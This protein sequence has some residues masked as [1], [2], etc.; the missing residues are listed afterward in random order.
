[1]LVATSSR[2]RFPLDGGRC[3]DRWIASGS[4]AV[5][6]VAVLGHP[7]GHSRSP[8]MHNAAFRELGLDWRYEAI[9]VEPERFEAVVREL[10]AQGYAGANVTIPHKLRAL[11]VADTASD[12]R[13]RPWAP[14]TRSSSRT[15]RAR[16]QHRRAGLPHRPARAR[17][18]GAGGMR[19]LVLGAGGAGARRRLRA[20]RGGAARV[21]VWNRHPERAEALVGRPRRVPRP[22]RSLQRPT[23]PSLDRTDLLVNATSVGM[24]SHGSEPACTGGTAPHQG[25]TAIGR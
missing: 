9:D 10:P 15:A 18:G 3:I 21:E 12:G 19:A 2:V 17:A 1:M 11:E 16:R 5:M 13:A 25:A 6:R 8:A 4:A 20:A 14:P 7:V 22:T 24:A 23:R